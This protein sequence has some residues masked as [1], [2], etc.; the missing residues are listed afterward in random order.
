[1]EI[2]E[3]NNKELKELVKENKKV[4]VDCYAV[5]CGPCK[6]LSPII[7]QLASEVES[8]N[9]YKINVDEDDEISDEY[10]I[11][12]IPTLLYFEDGKLKEQLVGLKTKDELLELVG[13]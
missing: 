10:N 9:F 7:D 3:L 12:S 4:L 5:W 1:M 13:E 8:T 2:K 6:M 11:S